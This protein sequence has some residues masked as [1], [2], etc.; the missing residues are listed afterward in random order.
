MKVRPNQGQ[1]WKPPS[2]E[3]QLI[4]LI[5][6]NDMNDFLWNTLNTKREDNT[7]IN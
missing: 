2:L 4:Y 5:L 3:L 7:N 1:V 6:A